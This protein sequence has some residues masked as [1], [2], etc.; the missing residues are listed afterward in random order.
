MDPIEL[1][2]DMIQLNPEISVGVLGRGGEFVLVPTDQDV[3]P[4]MEEAARRG[5]KY[6]GFFVV[7]RRGEPGVRCE[8]DPDS[9]YTMLLASLAFAQLVAERLKPKDDFE[10]FAEWLAC[11]FRP[12]RHPVKKSV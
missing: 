1:E 2:R 4:A 10:K 8:P 7:T 6:C 11:T 12:A 5:W 9:I 3:E